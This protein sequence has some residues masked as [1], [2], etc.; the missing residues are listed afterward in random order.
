MSFLKLQG[1]FEMWVLAVRTLR[2]ILSQATHLCTFLIAVGKM[3]ILW[4]IAYLSYV[5][6][7]EWVNFMLEK[8]AGLPLS[9]LSYWWLIVCLW[10]APTLASFAL[11]LQD[12]AGNTSFLKVSSSTC[13]KC[14]A[15][16]KYACFLSLSLVWLDKCAF[17]WNLNILHAGL[18]RAYVMVLSGALHLLFPGCGYLSWF[19]PLSPN[20]RES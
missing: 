10:R 14:P 11:L 4:L 2:H 19:W 6:G 12:T 17:L 18:H 15:R 13:F 1:C 7:K 8:A 20:D 16:Q 9:A 3:V 5:D